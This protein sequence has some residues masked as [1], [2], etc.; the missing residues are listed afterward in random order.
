MALT[1]EY[2]VF[3]QEKTGREDFRQVLHALKLPST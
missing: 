1:A 3:N 2:R